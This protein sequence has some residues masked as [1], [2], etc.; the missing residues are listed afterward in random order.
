MRKEVRSSKVEA[1]KQSIVILLLLMILIGPAARAQDIFLKSG[2]RITTEGVRRDGDVVMGKVQV[3]TGS[4]EVGYQLAQIARVDFP[5]PG[6]L[7]VAAEL[8]AAKQP[9][10]ALA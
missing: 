10:K 4:G 3:G 6:A 2:Q 9:D 1:R 5:E 7:K 8:L